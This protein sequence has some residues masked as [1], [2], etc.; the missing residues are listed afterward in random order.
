MSK[1]NAIQEQAARLIAQG[2]DHG[3]IIE[4]IGVSRSTFYRWQDKQQFK[5]AV[6]RYCQK[7]RE[8]QERQIVAEKID[9]AQ[10]VEQAKQII[11]DLMFNAERDTTRMQAAR[12]IIDRWEPTTAPAEN[13][14]GFASLLQKM[15][16]RNKI[17]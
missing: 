17:D 7:I 12:Y 3:T 4:Q 14:N 8:E 11:I 9:M 16:E 2:I 1:L 6:S 13:N 10:Y 5:A 15:K